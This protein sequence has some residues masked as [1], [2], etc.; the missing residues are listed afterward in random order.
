MSGGL[1]PEEAISRELEL[2]EKSTKECL[3]KSPLG[4]IFELQLPHTVYPP[5]EDT[6]L[7]AKALTKLGPGRGRKCLEIGTGSGVLSLLCNRQGW[8]ASCCDINPLAVASAKSF[9]AANNA[10][11]INISEGGP[12]PVIDGDVSQWTN[13]EKYDLIF[14]NLPYLTPSKNDKS[15]LGP[16]EDAA[17]IDTGATDLFHI[18]T[19]TIAKNELLNKGGLVLFLLSGDK[20]DNYLET[21]S[22]HNGF[23]LRTVNEMIFD[24]G[25]MIRVVAMWRPYESAMKKHVE[26]TNS[27]NTEMLRSNL[28]IGS[29]LSTDFQIDGHGRRGRKWE[30]AGES[31]ACSWKIG[32]QTNSSPI[33]L[34]LTC[35]FVV[36]KSL[37]SLPGLD[38][39][40][41]LILKW[42]NDIL[43]ANDDN[44]CKVSGI[45]LESSS[46]DGNNTVVLGVG[47]NLRPGEFTKRDFEMGY[48]ETITAAD[49]N[50]LKEIIECR[51]AGIFEQKE[52]I[53]L[54]PIENYRDRVFEE[55]KQGF[56]TPSRLFYRK[57]DVSFEKLKDEGLLI[58]TDS[59]GCEY[60]CD[61]GE[62][63]IWEFN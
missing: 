44:F 57:R 40:K 45:L 59:E 23:A 15:F 39:E 2:I 37:Q 35:G 58:V 54:S 32:D 61:D 14:W 46:I 51:I 41:T 55:V 50:V 38:K 36:L 27:T 56:E 42:P 1:F 33:L 17:L 47:I 18:A 49:K 9:F 29:S 10:T 21:I 19:K 20:D 43:V 13:G 11:E 5:R 7:L 28:V 25:E 63:I 30:N 24:D 48:L 31:F 8:N 3:W 60:V 4:E 6:S 62:S 34:Q 16:M 53:P 12:G 52:G 26:S 22:S